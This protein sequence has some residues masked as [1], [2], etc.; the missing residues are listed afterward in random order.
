MHRRY[1]RRPHCCARPAGR[2]DAARDVPAVCVLDPDGDILR[3]LRQAGQAQRFDSWPCYHTELHTF[4]LA[5][6][7]AGIV[8]CAVGAPFA[9]LIAEQL[10]ACGCRFWSA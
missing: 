4:A 7:T 6:G 5:G 1:S 8:G 2:R 9:V 3:R 10:F